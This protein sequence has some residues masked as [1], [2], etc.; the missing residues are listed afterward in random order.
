VIL[1]GAF[2]RAS[3]S[4]DGCGPSWPLCNGQVVPAFVHVKTFIEFVHRASIGLLSPLV[5][6]LIVWAFIANPKRHPARIGA[7]L[8]FFFTIVEAL[9]GAVLVKYKLVAHNDSGLRA[10]IMAIHL[11]STFLLLGS[12]TL[13]AWWS[14]DAEGKNRPKFKGQG[15]LGWALGV[16]IAATLLLAVSGAVT[17]LGDTLYRPGTFVEGI[18]QDFAPTKHLLLRLR[19]LHPLIAMSVCLYLLLLVGL[20]THLRP[21]AAVRKYASWIG[22]VFMTEIGIGVINVLSRAAIPMQLI[23]LYVADVLWIVLVLLTGAALASDAPWAETRRSEQEERELGVATWRDY[24]A[25]TKPRVISLLL[26]TTLAAMFIAR[27]PAHRVTPLLFIAVAIGGYMAAGSANAINMVVDQ[28]IDGRMKRT[29]Q[30]PTVTHKISSTHALMFAFVL[31]VSSFLILW[32]TANLLSAMLAL[33][34]LVFYVVIYTLLLKRR[35]WHNI[36]IGGAAGAFP[37]L[38][39]WAAV[40]GSLSPLAWYLFAIIFVWTP[41]H[42]WA[43]ALLI[44][45]DY[46]DA[47]IPMLPVV[48]GERATVIQIGMYAILTAIVSVMPLLQHE[49]QVGYLYLFAAVLLNAALLLR[50]AQ[51]LRSPDRPRASSLF[52]YSMIY[53]ALLFLMMAV[54]RGAMAHPADVR[55]VVSNGGRH[56]VL[57]QAG[58]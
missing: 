9:V 51:L 35:T 21:S 12:L 3:L 18:A 57:G 29:T 31:E 23:H 48:R 17:A 49:N 33:A 6:L 16:A 40:T 15:A 45:D 5:I 19:V 39:G 32:L 37:P 28:D 27:D 34:G 56:A 47:G 38:V 8:T 22:L 52:H 24:L 44:K 1:W 54:D 14:G 55:P 26:F 13:T 46:A 10:I 25:L 20:V 4:G 43:L 41:V 58:E 7:A 11:V 2:V 53:L 36:V 30:R 42:F 50:S